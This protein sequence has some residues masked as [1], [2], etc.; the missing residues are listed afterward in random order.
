VSTLN[1]Y[2]FQQTCRH[3]EAVHVYKMI[4]HF[5][6]KKGKNKN[7]YWY[8]QLSPIPVA[9]IR[10]GSSAARLL[11]SWVRIPPGAW[12]FVLCFFVWTIT[13]N[14]RWHAG[15]KGFQQYKWIKGE[16]PG[17]NNKKK[18]RLG[19]VCLSVVS[20]VCC[21]VE[22]SATGWSFV[23][24]SPTDCGVSNVCDREASKNEAA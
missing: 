16:N 11:G 24:R 19:H 13:W 7:I 14:I 2:M 20:V 9:G 10:R 5:A 8:Y 12:M 6:G 1:S 22:V 4:V 23:Q 17:I 15:Q 3:L 18:S 21:Q